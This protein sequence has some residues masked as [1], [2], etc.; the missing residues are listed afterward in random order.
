MER[1]FIIPSVKLTIL[2]GGCFAYCGRFGVASLVW[3]LLKSNINGIHFIPHFY[4]NLT[5][6]HFHQTI[7][8]KWDKGVQAKIGA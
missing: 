2:M 7:F 1:S 5:Y 3:K 8:R 4:L 6:P